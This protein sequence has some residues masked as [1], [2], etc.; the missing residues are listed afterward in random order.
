M[1]LLLRRFRA[2]HARPRAGHL[3]Q[4]EIHV[5]IAPCGWRL[6]PLGHGADVWRGGGPRCAPGSAPFHHA[7]GAAYP[8]PRS[9]GRRRDF[10]RRRGTRPSCVSAGIE[11]R[12]DEVIAGLH[13]TRFRPAFQF[14]SASSFVSCP[15]WQGRHPPSF[16]AIPTTCPTTSASRGC[17]MMR[18]GTGESGCDCSTS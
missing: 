18:T 9:V 17:V 2:A 4:A 5:G 10:S 12:C 15:R 11:W 13:G 6:L 16:I 14:S 3:G 8:R 1:T 7:A